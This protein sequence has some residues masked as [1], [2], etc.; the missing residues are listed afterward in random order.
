VDLLLEEYQWLE[1]ISHNTFTKIKTHANPFGS[2]MDKLAPRNI[3]L[4]TLQLYNRHSTTVRF[5]AFACT[6]R[7]WTGWIGCVMRRRSELYI[8]FGSVSE[9]IPAGTSI[10]LTVLNLMYKR[11]DF[12][13]V[14]ELMIISINC[15]QIFN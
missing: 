6:V 10:H 15:S 4:E 14:R 7:D 2:F 5:L 11:K 9:T 1:A 3:F 12:K 13:N 8:A